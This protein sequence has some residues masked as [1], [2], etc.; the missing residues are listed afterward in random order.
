MQTIAAGITFEPIS[1]YD[2]ETF[3]AVGAL[4]IIDRLDIQHRNS[5]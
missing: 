5:L 2:L 4:V 3:T 1:L